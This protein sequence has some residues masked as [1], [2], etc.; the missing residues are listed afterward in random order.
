M[1]K[2]V[3]AACVL[4]SPAF[5]QDNVSVTP[6]FSAQGAG[7]WEMICHVVTGDGQRDIVLS[8]RSPRFANATLFSASCSYSA[9]GKGDLV[10]TINGAAKCPFKGAIETACT[11]TTRKG[12]PGAFEFKAKNAR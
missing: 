4:A 2:V 3:L 12:H 6:G 5:A 11:E 1:W 9:T 8:P 10:V 7:E